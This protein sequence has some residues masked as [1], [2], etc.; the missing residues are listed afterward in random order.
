M[1]RSS[2]DRKY[3]IKGGIGGYQEGKKKKETNMRKYS[4]LLLSFLNNV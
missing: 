3:M 2:S 4:F 1:T